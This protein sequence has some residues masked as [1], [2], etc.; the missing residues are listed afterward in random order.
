MALSDL[1]VCSD[2]VDSWKYYQ[3]HLE[4]SEEPD[5]FISWITSL[6]YYCQDIVKVLANMTSYFY[7]K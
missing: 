6:V 4:G 7:K 2:G 5:I 3:E 1:S